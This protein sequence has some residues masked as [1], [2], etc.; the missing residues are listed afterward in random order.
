MRIV[1][2]DLNRPHQC[3]CFWKSCLHGGVG[4]AA[5][6]VLSSVLMLL[7]FFLIEAHTERNR[8]ESPIHWFAP[9]LN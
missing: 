9:Y 2:A 6:F 7:L 1:L 4:A 3:F 8:V 5:A